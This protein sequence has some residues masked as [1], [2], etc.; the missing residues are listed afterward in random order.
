MGQWMIFLLFG[1][2]ALWLLML[3][4][5]RSRKDR[6][7]PYERMPVAHRGLHDLSARIPENSLSAFQRAVTAGYGI[8][9]DV[10]E[11][12]DEQ[13]VVMHDPG[14]LRMTGFNMKVAET[15]L[16]DLEGI[17]LKNSDEHIPELREVL[18]LVQGRVPLVIEIKCEEWK[19]ERIC[20]HVAYE[21]D[22]Y[23]GPACIESFHPGVL[24]WFY[25]NR[26]QVLR[27]QLSERFLGEKGLRR[28]LGLPASCCLA[29]F[30]THPDFIAYDC[31]QTHLIRFQL[32]R[33]VLRAE[34]A[35]WTVRS[36]EDMKRLAR[37]FDVFIF[38][39]FLPQDAENEE[40]AAF[41]ER[42]TGGSMRRER[43]MQDRIRK[44]MIVTGR[45][46]GVGFRYR[47]TYI[48]QGLDVTGWVKNLP[49][50]SV[51]ME[52]QGTEVQLDMMMQQLRAQQW[53]VIEGV[54]EKKIPTVPGEYEFKVRY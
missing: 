22:R 33:Y 37:D 7:A 41:A 19:A 49:D 42:N 43:N 14:L 4:P 16:A 21:L 36:A 9:L 46:Q 40:T 12:Y 28:L 47:A 35:A 11:T 3:N 30:L 23:E 48:A 39:G 26:P 17:Y 54:R 27:G 45:V 6:M 51:E 10:R 15:R 44:H 29:N 24:R 32:L 13:L 38:E 31:R 1:L 52:L 25:K 8:E 50:D 2:V 18:S 20:E 5:E 34:T 53:I